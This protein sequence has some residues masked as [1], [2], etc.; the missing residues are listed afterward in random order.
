MVDP[1]DRVGKVA[2]AGAIGSVAGGPQRAGEKVSGLESMP[3]WTPASKGESSISASASAGQSGGSRQAGN[4]DARCS[5]KLT[6]TGN[7]GERGGRDF[8][9]QFALPK[10]GE[11]R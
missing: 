6:P 4:K 9:N 2:I 3:R 8:L 1:D 10:G 11:P 7:P 5:T